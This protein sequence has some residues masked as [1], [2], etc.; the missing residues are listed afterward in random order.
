MKLDCVLTACNTN[1]LYYGFIPL[2]I[3]SWKKLYPEVDVKVILINDIIPD[4]LKEYLDNIILYI[5]PENVSTAFISQYIRI[6]YPSILKYKNGIIISD[7]DMLPM[8]NSYYTKPIEHI[9]DNKFIAF[10]P[11]WVTGCNNQICICYNIALSTTWSTIFNI[12]NLEDISTRLKEI[13]SSIVYVDGHN[14]SGWSTDQLDLHK[15]VIDWNTKTNNFIVLDD[16]ETKYR[17]LDR[18]TFN[19]NP[20]LINLIKSGYFSDYHVWRPYLQYK[21]IN[22]TI[23][24]IL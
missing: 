20:N 10:R 15:Y 14:K 13:H 5:P 7:I 17:R 9:D 12:H 3:K 22:D 24:D 19:L 18:G 6:L 4:D 8:N 11:I 23:V 16:N 21:E 2:F 1:P